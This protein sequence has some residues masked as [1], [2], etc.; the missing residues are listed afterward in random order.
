MNNNDKNQKLSTNYKDY[1]YVYTGYDDFIKE[2]HLD[3]KE[4][5][6]EKEKIIHDHRNV[7]DFNNPNQHTHD[8]S[9]DFSQ[10]EKPVQQ[11]TVYK[12]RYGNVYNQK[13][14]T[15]SYNNINRTTTS[16]YNRTNYNNDAFK[17][18]KNLFKLII[19]VP[20]ILTIITS[21]VP[22]LIS[23]YESEQG[24][25]VETNNTAQLSVIKEDLC[26]AIEYNDFSMI[27]PYLIENEITYYGARSW[28]KVI[29]NHDSYGNP[30]Y[31]ETRSCQ[32][33]T[34]VNLNLNS[35]RNLENEYY[36]KYYSSQE[37]DDAYNM[38]IRV[39]GY[40]AKRYVVTVILIDNEWKLFKIY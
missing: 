19:I 40:Y 4:I 33:M 16:S 39:T 30:N 18:A 37:I 36:S 10:E 26:E 38:E 1:K 32:I 8:Y 21:M 17:T 2:H 23:I 34:S 28:K 35:I 14:T 11:K 7:F 13:P 5:K 25:E 29:E 12:D 27:E 20:I 31:N 15:T 22:F 3:K 6:E 24:I 9:F